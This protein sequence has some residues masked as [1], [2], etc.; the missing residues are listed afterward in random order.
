MLCHWLT[1]LAF[2][3]HYT[4]INIV[5]QVKFDFHPFTAVICIITCLIEKL[6]YRVTAMAEFTVI[7]VTC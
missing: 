3:L 2:T 1:M 6:S 5:P 4:A 7:T